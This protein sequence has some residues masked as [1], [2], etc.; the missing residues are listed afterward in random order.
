MDQKRN[1]DTFEDLSSCSSY[2]ARVP[3]DLASLIL[4]REGTDWKNVIIRKKCGKF[5]IVCGSKLNLIGR[6]VDRPTIVSSIIPAAVSSI[7]PAALLEFLSVVCVF[8]C[9]CTN[10]DEDMGENKKKAD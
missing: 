2:F 3:E 9:A 4:R 1:L 8:L 5:C 10:L 6:N 7:I